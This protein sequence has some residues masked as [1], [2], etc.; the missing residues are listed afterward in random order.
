MHADDLACDAALVTRLLEEQGLSTGEIPLPL[1]ETGT[2]NRLYLLGEDRVVRVP[3]MPAAAERLTKELE[4]LPQLAP[5]LPIEIPVPLAAGKASE[6]YPLPFAVYSWIHGEDAATTPPADL[7]AEVPRLAQFLQAMQGL[8]FEGPGPGSHN[9]Y[10][11][12]SL[13]ERDD[14]TR[15]CLGELADRISDT[16]RL[17]EVWE[18]C[19]NAP[20]STRSTWLHGDLTP[21]NMLVHEGRLNAVI[22][23]GGAG[24]GDPAC[25]LL[26]AYSLLDAP[27]R[28]Q[29]RAELDVD[30]A[31]WLRGRGWAL[32]MAAVALPYYWDTLPVLVK[33]AHRMLDQVRADSE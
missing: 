15:R 7:S 11:G 31:T 2:E 13:A 18:E 3:R 20:E 14:I 9:F 29:L 27:Q 25:D 24:Y 23:F 17:E 30:D 28:A 33:E 21:R 12:E 26:V 32:A 1:P 16:A 10:R 19:L 6:T 4:W 8:D 5:H 22:D